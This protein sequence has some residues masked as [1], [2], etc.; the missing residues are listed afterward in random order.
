M[1]IFAYFGLVLIGLH[2]REGLVLRTAIHDD[3][4]NIAI[5]LALD[6]VQCTL[7]YGCRIVGTGNNCEFD[8]IR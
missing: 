4:L 2:H 7:Q 5:G 3:V 6:T 1:S 8:H